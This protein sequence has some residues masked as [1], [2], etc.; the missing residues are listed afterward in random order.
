MLRLQSAY[1]PGD[2]HLYMA[3]LFKEVLKVVSLTFRQQFLHWGRFENNSCSQF[4]GLSRQCGRPVRAR[5]SMELGRNPLINGLI[6]HTF[7]INF[8][9]VEKFPVIPFDQT[10][11]FLLITSHHVVLKRFFFKQKNPNQIF[12]QIYIHYMQ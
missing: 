12:N 5:C 3:P 9:F 8:L 10:K 1:T 6:Q 11:F 4:Y 2:T 7:Q